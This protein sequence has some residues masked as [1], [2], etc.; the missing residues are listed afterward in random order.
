MIVIK[1]ISID[2]SKQFHEIKMKGLLNVYGLKMVGKNMFVRILVD[3][4]GSLPRTALLYVIK[5]DA[6]AAEVVNKRLKYINCVGNYNL[7]LL[8]ILPK[9]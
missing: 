8:D 7:F 9:H 1:D 6:N 5:T 3:E 2:S 4:I